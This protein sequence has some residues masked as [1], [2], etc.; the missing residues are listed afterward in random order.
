[1][2]DFFRFDEFNL[3]RSGRPAAPDAAAAATWQNVTLPARLDTSLPCLNTT[4]P[5]GILPAIPFGWAGS[6]LEVR[7]SGFHCTGA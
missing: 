7:P 4:Q 1:M 6:G 2:P 5:I 3:A